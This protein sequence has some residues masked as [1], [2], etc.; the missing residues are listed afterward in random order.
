LEKRY[1]DWGYRYCESSRIDDLTTRQRQKI[2][3]AEQAET[4]IKHLQQTGAETDSLSD[5]AAITES[6]REFREEV[7]GGA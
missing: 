7:R 4:Y 5:P 6:R 3:L 2:M 1:H